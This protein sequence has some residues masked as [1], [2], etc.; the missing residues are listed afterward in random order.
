MALGSVLGSQESGAQ[1]YYRG[2]DINYDGWCNLADANILEGYLGGN[3]S[4]VDFC[5]EGAD[6]NGNGSVTGIDLTAMIAFFNGGPGPVGFCPEVTRTCDP[7]EEA[8]IWLTPIADGDPDHATFS[9]YVE[10]T[11]EIG[12]L[13]FSFEYD[14]LDIV[15]FATANH[16]NVFA[17]K[18]NERIIPPIAGFLVECDNDGNGAI[19][20][21]GVG[22]TRIFDIFITRQAGAPMSELRIVEDPIHGPAYFYFGA[23][24]HCAGED[25]ICPFG[26][27]LV[28]GDV[29]G[30]D[31]Y[32]G[33]DV[34]YGVNFFKGG[35]YPISSYFFTVPVQWGY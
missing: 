24:A 27:L 12:A 10:A 28:G 7:S 2:G 16:S 8:T 14:P 22:G 26:P 3:C 20:P 25:V 23:G 6:F 33:L 17:V 31:S 11:T 35:S 19:Y 4:D 34:T 15:S 29:N 32:N 30:S 21:T 5:M 18:V 1:Q 13:N 9:V